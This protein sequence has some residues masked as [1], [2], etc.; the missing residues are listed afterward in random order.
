VARRKRKVNK[1]QAVRDYLAA[2]PDQTPKEVVSALGVQGIAV[3]PQY[4]SAIKSK[5]S[6]GTVAAAPATDA[7]SPR[8]RRGRPRRQETVAASAVEYKNLLEAKSFVRSIGG[9]S[10]ARK[11]LDAYANL[12]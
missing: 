12:Q 1:S 4:V 7:P 5:A 11:V 9:I 2:N 8:R 3:K 6:R 10:E